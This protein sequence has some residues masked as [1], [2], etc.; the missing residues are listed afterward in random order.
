MLPFEFTVEGPPV[1]PQTS[2]PAALRAFKRRVAAAAL[3]RLDRRRR[4]VTFAVRIVATFYHEGKVTR[5]DL[6]NAVKP[7]Q[8]ALNGLIYVDDRQITDAVLRKTPL[9]EPIRAR[10]M[11]H[12]LAEGFVENREFI[13]VRVEAAPSHV[14]PL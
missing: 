8:D 11:S 6:D 5:R 7:I 14:E 12:V 3:R 1:S 10:G 4:P 2:H 13:Y 9:D